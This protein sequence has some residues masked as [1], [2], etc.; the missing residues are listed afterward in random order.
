MSK[1]HLRD[2]V[3]ILFL[4]LAAFSIVARLAVLGVLSF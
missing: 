1:P 2:S 3:W 4:L